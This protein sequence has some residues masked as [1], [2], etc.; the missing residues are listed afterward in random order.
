VGA[1]PYAAPILILPKS[2]AGCL[3]HFVVAFNFKTEP[4]AGGVGRLLSAVDF[5]LNS[6]L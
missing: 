5:F 2:H 6:K 4:L 3:T 1:I